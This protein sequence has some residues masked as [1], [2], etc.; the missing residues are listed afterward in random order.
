M[1]FEIFTLADVTF[2]G[3]GYVQMGCLNADASL[4]IASSIKKQNGR[5]LEVQV[6]LLELL[7]KRMDN[8]IL[9]CRF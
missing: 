4:D 9:F 2:I 7:D 5:Y 1:A 3:K 8:I 6:I